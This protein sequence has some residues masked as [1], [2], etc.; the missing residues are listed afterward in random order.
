MRQHCRRRHAGAAVTAECFHCGLPVAAGVDA[1]TGIDA[2]VR[3]TVAIGGKARA[4]C[5]PG[6]QAV[7]Q[8]IVD[9]G[10]GDYYDTRTGYGVTASEAT[11]TPSELLL[12]DE[13]DGYH[14]QAGA[15]G[16]TAGGDVEEATFSVG[17]IRCGACV[18]LIER[19]LAR[20]PGV[21]GVD[22][23]VATERLH[24]RWSRQACSPGAILKSLQ[25]IGYAAFP[26]DTIA[27]GERMEHAR[28]MLF[29]RLFIAGLSMMQ[30]MMYALPVYLAAAGTMERDIADLMRWA[31]LLLTLPAVFY[32]AQPFFSG[33]WI[34]LKN[35]MP[36]MDVPVSLGIAAAFIGSTYATLRGHG[37][38]YFDSVTMFIF[39]LLCSRYAELVARRKAASALDDLQRALPASALLMRDYPDSRATQLVAAGK[40]R[41]GDVILVRPGDA[42]AADGLVLEGDTAIDAS[43]LTG[44]SRALHKSAGATLPGGAVNISQPVV[45]Q[46]ARSAADSTLSALVKLIEHSGQGKPRLSRWADRAAVWFVTLLL[47]FAVLVFVVWQVFDPSRAWAVAIAVMVVSCPCALSLA[48]P[49]ALAAAT[50]SLV[51]RGALIVGSHVLEVLDRTTHIVFDKTGTLTL[52]KPVLQNIAQLGRE[53]AARCLQIAAA[54]EGGSAHPLA[55]AIIQAAQAEAIAGTGDE[56]VGNLRHVPGQGI[57]GVI[58]GCR[59]RL[60]NAAFV[61]EIA[62]GAAIDFAVGDVTPVFLGAEKT[63]LARLDLADGLRPDAQAIV[64]KFQAMGKEVIL[65]SGDRQAVVT[66]VASR[67]GIDAACGEQSPEQKLAFLRALQ[68]SGGVVAMIGD[69]INDAAVLHA[70]DVSFAMGGGAALAQLNADCLLLSGR[71]STLGEVSDVASR[72]IRII[73]QNLAWATLY[74]LVAIPAAAFGLLNPWLSGIGMSLSSAVVVLNA[75]RLRRSARTPEAEETPLP[76]Q[77]ILRPIAEA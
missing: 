21:L 35:R 10:L 15:A 25:E 31:G 14:D 46:V 47:L 20:L 16:A 11:L 77:P 8:S 3:W 36:G 62:G 28:K 56:A 68:G 34:S 76:P 4:M 61:E 7:A 67:L 50:D 26:F 70:A 9:N 43:L 24:V 29:R 44:E 55:G 39:L 17:G 73:R 58:G 53:P 63:W 69:G 27:H 38:V 1:N 59:Y 72:T 48:T 51:R 74:N 66:Q 40:L 23:N 52:G 57:E 13:D 60:G 12:Y 45:V 30:V 33:A 42:F 19:R 54:L 65:L 22:L 5:C 2:G 75:L 71:L 18:W 37:E 32:S 6:C 64:K 41:S 49:A